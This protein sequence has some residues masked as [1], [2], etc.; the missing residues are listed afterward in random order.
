MRDTGFEL[1]SRPRPDVAAGGDDP[2][3]G[4]AEPGLRR[5]L[6]RAARNRANPSR[7]G[8]YQRWT[9]VSRRKSAAG[10]RS[11]TAREPAHPVHDGDEQM[12]SEE[13][14]GAEAERMHEV[15]LIRDIRHAVARRWPTAN[16]ASARLSSLT[17]HDRFCHS[18]RPR[19]GSHRPPRGAAWSR[20]RRPSSRAANPG[21]GP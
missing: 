2:A 10:Q 3:I 8:R 13:L 17:N 1:G 14:E 7:R 15:R 18:W 9:D 4:P 11:A 12:K 21:C 16:S 20:Q 5:E 19:L 6:S